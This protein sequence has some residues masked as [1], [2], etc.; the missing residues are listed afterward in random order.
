MAGRQ[1]LP[2]KP[3]SLQRRNDAPV[4]PEGI[5]VIDETPA[6]GVNLKFGGGISP[7]QKKPLLLGPMK[8]EVSEPLNITKR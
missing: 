6:V 5:V 4:R 8:K 2:H 7:L 1:Q 3:L